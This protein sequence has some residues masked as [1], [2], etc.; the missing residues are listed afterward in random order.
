MA[1]SGTYAFNPD[2]GD[3]VEEAF[4]R[5]GLELRSG[6][7]LRTARRSLNFLTLEW[8]NRGINLWTIEEKFI[9]AASDGTPLENNYLI[10]DTA[11]YRLDVGTISLLDMVLR[12]NDGNA[13]TQTDFQLNRISEPTFATIPNKLSSARPLQFYLQRIEIL[14]AGS[15]G[16]D[17]YDTVTFWPVPDNSTKY[18]VKYWRMKRI[19]D[20]GDNA[21]NTMQVPARFLPALV[22]GLAYHIACKRPEAESR[23]Q[24]LKQQYEEIFTEAAEEDRMKASVRF[25]PYIPVY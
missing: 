19:A 10:K 20:T 5:A 2:I 12:T 23:L 16:A 15:E 1:I 18:K 4:E 7:D 25:V 24:M 22:S 13:N 11:S 21:G 6:H 8:Q 14:G 9:D 17:Q 3:I